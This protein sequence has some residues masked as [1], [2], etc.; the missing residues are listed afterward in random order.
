MT[1]EEQVYAILRIN[2][3]N[4]GFEIAPHQSLTSDLGMDSLVLMVT[5][6]ELEDRFSIEIPDDK[7][8]E[9]ITVQDT[10][11]CVTEIL[12]ERDEGH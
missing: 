1:S 5:V 4:P 8:D 3:G 12:G 6:M 7:L 2:A 11:D 10:I 9:I